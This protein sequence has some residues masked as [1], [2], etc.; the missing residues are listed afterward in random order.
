MK[1]LLIPFVVAFLFASHANAQTLVDGSHPER[2]SAIAEQFGSARLDRS[3]NGDP[4]IIGKLDSTVYI[5]EFSGCKDGTDCLSMRFRASYS[6]PGLSDVDMGSWN[7]EQRFLKAFL[8][9][10]GDPVI[11]MSVNLVGGITEENVAAV[12]ARWVDFVAE[13]ENYI[14]WSRS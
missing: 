9:D 6:R 14:G 7:R 2:I 5:V 1:L 3:P 10:T 11:H 8:D 4:L 12:F 13:F